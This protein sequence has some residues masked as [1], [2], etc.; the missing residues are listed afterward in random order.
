MRGGGGR[1]GTLAGHT[2]SAS[3]IRIPPAG[4]TMRG[5]PGREGRTSSASFL[6][7]FAVTTGDGSS[8]N[9]FFFDAVAAAAVTGGA[10]AA[11]R[12]ADTPFSALPSRARLRG[13]LPLAFP[14]MMHGSVKGRL[15]R[16][17]PQGRKA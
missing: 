8:T 9:S 11:A 2:S 12:G 13:L 6:M 16:T 1:K 15:F 5:G 17:P 3:L 10:A 14:A 7:D 4:R